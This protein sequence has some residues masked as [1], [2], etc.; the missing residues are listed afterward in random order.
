MEI[1]K[2]YNFDR[3]IITEFLR[4]RE[5]YF[6]IREVL[7]MKTHLSL[8]SNHVS[9]I[10]H[11][12]MH[13]VLRA[14]PVMQEIEYFAWTRLFND[15]YR[16]G[17]TNRPDW[18]DHYYKQGYYNYAKCDKH[19]SCYQSG[20]TLWDLWDKDTTSCQIINKDSEDNFN[21]A[22]GI[23]I[24]NSH[25]EWCDVFDFCTTR[26]NIRINEFYISNIVLFEKF[27][28][29]FYEIAASL[30]KKSIN[31]KFKLEYDDVLDIYNETPDLIIIPFSSKTNLL[32][33]AHL[34]GI[35]A[36]LSEREIECLQWLIKGKTA[37][38]IAVILQISKRTV[39]KHMLNIKEKLGCY[40]LFQTGLKIGCYGN[41]SLFTDDNK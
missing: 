15:G 36:N 39:E 34:E 8:P 9:L 31:N 24:I 27:T 28:Q 37:G 23:S 26:S 12:E 32:Q 22:H 10:S 2:R 5:F 30:I 11:Y 20:Y 29:Y 14:F 40:T 19:P 3:C 1:K 4:S 18:I 38:E 16:A 25:E 17:L 33:T 13:T 6:C 7:F 21:L 41:L 35:H